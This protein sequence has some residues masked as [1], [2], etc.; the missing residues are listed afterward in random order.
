MSKRVKKTVS[1]M[2]YS[3]NKVYRRV[4]SMEP[5]TFLLTIIAIAIAV[6]LFGGGVYD[7]VY[8]PYPA[9]YSNSTGTFIFLYPSLSSQFIADSAFAAILYSLGV[10][11]LIVMYQST[12]YAYKPRQAYFMLVIGIVLFFMAYAFL[13]A[14]IHAKGGP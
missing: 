3:F 12:K 4:S 11:G 13:E 9:I 1:S 6:F 14:T 5:S 10:V 7:V 8:S 2:S